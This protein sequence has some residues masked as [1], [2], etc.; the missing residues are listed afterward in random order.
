VGQDG[1]LPDSAQFT[2]IKLDVEGVE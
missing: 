1:L 2:A